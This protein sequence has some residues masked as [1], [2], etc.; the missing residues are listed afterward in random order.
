M[1]TS[2]HVYTSSELALKPEDCKLS[3]AQEIER[4]LRRLDI[5]F[6]K[7]EFDTAF[8]VYYEALWRK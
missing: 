5:Q 4:V 7:K 3:C 1:K 2:T 6:A 8:D